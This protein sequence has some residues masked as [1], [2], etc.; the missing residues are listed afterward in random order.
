MSEQRP[1]SRLSRIAILLFTTST[2]ICFLIASFY[3]DVPATRGLPQDHELLP[4]SVEGIS[5]E[6]PLQYKKWFIGIWDYE[7]LLRIDDSPGTIDCL[8]KALDLESADLNPDLP[9]AWIQPPRWWTPSESS[10]CHCWMSEFFTLKEGGAGK[11]FF[12]IHDPGQKVIFLWIK[13][14]F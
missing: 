9:L 11:V 14:Y 5:F 4:K 13:S 8:V 12:A 10:K 6:N 7:Y 1:K 2:L 3:F